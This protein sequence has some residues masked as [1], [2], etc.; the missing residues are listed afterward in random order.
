[1]VAVSHHVGWH[2][3]LAP[4]KGWLFAAEG[5]DGTDGLGVSFVRIS[6]PQM[7]LLLR[8]A[9]RL[10]WRTPLQP[11]VS[12]LD[13]RL[14]SVEAEAKAL[15]ASDMEGCLQCW[16]LEE[17]EVPVWLNFHTKEG[18][19]EIR[20]KNKAGKRTCMVFVFALPLVYSLHSRG[21][22]KL[23][24]LLYF[25]CYLFSVLETMHLWL[26]RVNGTTYFILKL[27]HDLLEVCIHCL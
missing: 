12:Q 18:G 11:H 3:F 6:L 4:A 14:G 9:C 22:T 25:V 20:N 19:D 8:W 7:I 26:F 1:M 24:V 23:I 17:S 10:R 27:Y 2:N 16:V 15:V 5:D 21:T 13:L